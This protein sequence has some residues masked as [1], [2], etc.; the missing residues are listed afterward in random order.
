MA[1]VD[2]RT[3]RNFGPKSI[4][5]VTEIVQKYIPG[6]EPKPGSAQG[7]GEDTVRRDPVR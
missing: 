1:A 5:Q 4:E 7:R 3:L 2:F 6:W